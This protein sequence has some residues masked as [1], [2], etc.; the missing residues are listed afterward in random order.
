MLTFKAFMSAQERLNSLDVIELTEQSDTSTTTT[1]GVSNTDTMP[2]SH[3]VVIKKTKV[4]GHP[5]I[6]VDP[7]TFHKCIRGKQPFARWS[8]YVEDE[9]LRD[10]MKKTFAQSK[11]MLVANSRDGSM[12]YVK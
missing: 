2:L 7:E 5:C 3:K 12:V 6:E 10:E 1:A 11:R 9:K 4:F 8:K